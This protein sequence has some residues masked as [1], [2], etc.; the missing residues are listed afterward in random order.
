MKA[1]AAQG[2]ADV[3]TGA[4]LDAQNDLN[5]KALENTV[6]MAALQAALDMI[7]KIRS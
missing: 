2:K 6:A 3:T 4:A 7:K 1:S 5:Q